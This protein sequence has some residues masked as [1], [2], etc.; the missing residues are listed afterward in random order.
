MKKVLAIAPYKYLPFFS[1]GQKFIAGFF[2]HLA[3]NTELTVITVPENDLSLAKNYKTIPLLKTSFSRYID[4]TLYKKILKII[5]QEQIETVIWEHPYYAWL[6]IKLKKKTGI[7]IIIHTHN[8]EYQ[9]FR[10][11]GKWW[12]P[13]LRIY[14]KR[15]F[16]KADGIFF[17]TPEDKQFAIRQWKIKEEKCIDLPFGIEIK[18]Y[19]PDRQQCRKEVSSL[20]AIP[21]NTKILFFNGL[22][23]YKPNVDALKIILK[24][25]NPALL[26][27]YDFQYRILIAGKNL[28]EKFDSLKPWFDKNIIYTGFIR[29][30]GTYYKASDIFLNPVQIGGGIKTKMVESIAYGTT[31]V[32]TESGAVGIERSVCGE[33]LVIVKNEDWQSFAGEIV[34]NASSNT[35]TP[36]SYYEH[37]NWD[38]LVKRVVKVLS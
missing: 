8:I 24:E 32:S 21:E 25:I 10:S 36:P 29:D 7:K 23:D 4:R 22:L 17:I 16:K 28:P 15:F 34:K 12:W 9:R 31:V 20:H 18:E 14:E 2:E 11:V 37:Y 38:T 35:V 6:A 30:I 3:V 26:S 19:P 1:G 27:Q 13:V 5:E 33:K